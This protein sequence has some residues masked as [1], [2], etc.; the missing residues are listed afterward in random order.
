MALNFYPAAGGSPVKSI[1]RGT[2]ASAGNI[3]IT[4]VDTAKTFVRSYSS[5]S[6]GSVG[7]TGTS[8][9][10]LSPSVTAGN[11]EGGSSGAGA[12]GGWPS[13]SGTRTLAAGATALTAAEFG[14]YLV[15]STT[16][17]A[18]GA[19]NFEVVEYN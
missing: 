14:V 10:T 6:A 19:C 16:I 12:R 3:T 9:G 17:T 7:V 2:A 18:T 4:A 13:Y 8:T 1:Q 11:G 15:D 5:G